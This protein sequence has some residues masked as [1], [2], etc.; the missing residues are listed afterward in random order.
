MPKADH[1]SL[2]SNREHATELAE[3]ILD[4]AETFCR[5]RPAAG[6]SADI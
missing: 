2:L 1:T 4:F 5:V 6:K 3:H